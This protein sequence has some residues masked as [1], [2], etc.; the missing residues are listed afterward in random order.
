MKFGIQFEDTARKRFE[1]EVGIAVQH[2]GLFVD[3]EYGFLAAS[4][5][6][7]HSEDNINHVY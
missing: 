1:N 7:N 6:G 2:S 3:T 5:D 4:P